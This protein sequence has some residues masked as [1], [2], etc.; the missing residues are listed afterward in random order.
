VLFISNVRSPNLIGL[1]LLAVFISNGCT[2]REQNTL[3]VSVASSLSLPMQELLREFEKSSP[4]LK[5]NLNTGSSG[6]LAQQ[7]LNGAEVDLIIS[8]HDDWIEKLVSKQ[9]VERVTEANFL[10]NRLVVIVPK[11]SPLKSF[12]DFKTAD[13]EKFAVGA[14]GSVP[15]GEYAKIWL[16]KTGQ[17]NYFQD[18]FVFLKNEQQVLRA[19]ESHHAGAGVVYQSSVHQSDNIRVLYIPSSISYPRIR[20]SFA[21]QPRSPNA[22][23]VRELLTFLQSPEAKKIWQT[24]GFQVVE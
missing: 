13:L 11:N 14:F 3:T 22:E 7:I 10:G 1:L 6:A 2:N 20:Y 15:V 8:A 9:K 17:L 21:I 23:S 16:T 24:L 4:S 19:V 12:E 18:R 5:V